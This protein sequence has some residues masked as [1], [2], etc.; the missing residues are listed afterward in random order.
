MV[1]DDDF[2]RRRIARNSAVDVDAERPRV[3]GKR[4]LVET[5]HGH[6]PTEV[7][8]VP[9]KQTAVERH[10]GGAQG[11]AQ[12]RDPVVETPELQSRTK[13]TARRCRSE[14]GQHHPADS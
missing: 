14:Q 1:R 12:A 4:T 9:G 13:P 11:V 6:P 2:D 7:A 10:M 3:P 5:E 8:S